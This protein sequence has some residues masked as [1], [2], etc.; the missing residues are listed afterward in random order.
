MGFPVCK[1]LEGGAPQS[2]RD[3]VSCPLAAAS[4]GPPARKPP[5][6]PLTSLPCASLSLLGIWELGDLVRLNQGAAGLEDEVCA[7]L[8]EK[9]STLH[10]S[11]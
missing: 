9:E 8:V 2:P 3:P 4:L 10:L 11:S 6:V 1:D 7:F 5:S